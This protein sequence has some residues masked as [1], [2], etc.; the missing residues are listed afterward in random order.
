MGGVESAWSSY[1]G[2]VIDIVPLQGTGR[3]HIGRTLVAESNRCLLVRESDHRDQ[4]YFPREDID[5]AA[6]VETEHHT[7]CPFKGEASYCSVS[8]EGMLFENVMWWYRDPMPEVAGL[9]GYAAFYFDRVEVTASLP[10]D[11]GTE[12]TV[13]FPIWGT[14]DDLAT[15]MDVTPLDNDAFLAPMYPNPPIGTFFSLEWHK[16][17]RVVVE[18]GQLLGAAIVA[19]SKSRPDQRVISAHMAF[20]KSSSF[21]EPL[22]LTLDARHRGSTLSVFDVKIEQMGVLRAS[23]FVMTD[24]GSADLIRHVTAMPAVPAPAEC[25]RSDFGVLGREIRVVDGAYSLRDGPVGPPELYVWTRFTSAPTS[26]ALHQALLAQPTTHYSIGAAMR[27]HKGI[28]ESEA[29]RT[30]STGPID[31]TIAFHDDVDVS[32]WLL[33]ETRA[34]WAG[35]GC[36]QSQIRVFTEDGRLVASKTVQAIVRSFNRSPKQLGQD[37]S[38]VM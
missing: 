36:I 16:E 29:H 7:V 31:V 12:A 4:L 1:P 23:G 35:R 30:I 33:T 9:A 18:G 17:R 22:L 26:I 28:S 19:A 5:A 37:F 34:I 11:D 3:V 38:T 24:A 25:P 32:D 20:V 8:T 15:L 10:F 14:A 27:P 2:Y 6:L 13:H 21:D